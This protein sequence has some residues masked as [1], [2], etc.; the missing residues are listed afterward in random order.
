M[1]VYV[2]ENIHQYNSV[3]YNEFKICITYLWKEDAVYQIRA[4]RPAHRKSNL[5]KILVLWVADR[6]GMSF[7][8]LKLHLNIGF[9]YI[10]YHNP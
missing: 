2:F 5:F 10:T 7:F 3:K 4:H 8:H 9:C 6:N 1:C